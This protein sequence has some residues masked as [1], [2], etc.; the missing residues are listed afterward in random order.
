MNGRCSQ[1]PDKMSAVDENV[2]LN[3]NNRVGNFI[4]GVVEGFYGRPW[5]PDQRKDLFA[6]MNKFG[7][8]GYLYAPKDD[9][10]HRAY[11]REL[12]SVEE[13]EHLTSLIQNAKE[14]GVTFY[15][16][17][18]PGLDI[19]YSS[20]KELTYLKR[21]LEQVS[22][23]GCNAFALLFDDIEPDMCEADKEIFQSFAHAQVSVTNEV[24]QHLGQ[25][26]FL[27]CPTE[28]CSTR[29]V[30]SVPQSE[31][32]NTIGSKLLPGIDIMWTGQKVITKHITVASIKELTDVLKRPPVIWDNLHANDYDQKRVFLGPFSG[33]SPDLIPHLRGVLSNPNCEYEANFIAIHTLGHWS[34][35]SV[36]GNRDLTN[37]SISADIKLETEGESGSIEDIPSRISASTYHPKQ[38]LC[39]AINDW[40]REFSRPKCAYGKVIKPQVQV[41]QGALLPTINTCIT[42]TT[43]TTTTTSS[44]SQPLVEVTT[45]CQTAFQPS[46]NLIM[47]SLLSSTGEATYTSKA[48]PMDCVSTPGSSPPQELI[49]NSV[50]DN[51]Q[52]SSLPINDIKD[53]SKCIEDD[54][55]QLDGTDGDRISSKKEEP[56]SSDDLSLLVDLFYL[57]FEHGP[58]GLQ[59]LQEFNWLKSNVPQ[60][61]NSRKAWLDSTNEEDVQEWNA[62]ACKFDEMTQAV[63]R[64]YNKLVMVKN[65][66]LL[67]DLYPYMWDMKGV[68]N[69]LNSYVKWLGKRMQLAVT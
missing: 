13:A 27:F 19:T 5:S 32:L 57:P 55:M 11:W 17:L 25:P 69:L 39:A 4:C 37:D 33:R 59:F 9:C 48:E 38:A 58:K 62:R 35:C 16:A 8:N 23:F 50:L 12:Y 66:S 60:D 42:I 56:L 34:Q 45:V 3:G 51:R 30:P 24:Y 67:C 2:E 53:N 43:P 47:N 15:Y 1:S 52:L 21:K 40:L 20:A 44:L 65:R 61:L 10:K 6:K 28:Y 36:D 29:A 46:S 49:D 31:Y 18:S 14:N 26:K 54:G 64:L 63:S 41:P 22:Q 68:I 7:M